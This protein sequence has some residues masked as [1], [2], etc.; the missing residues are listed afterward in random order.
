MDIYGPYNGF[1]SSQPGKNFE[2]GPANLFPEVTR[3]RV[4]LHKNSNAYSPYDDF[5]SAGNGS[6]SA[7]AVAKILDPLNGNAVIAQATISIAANRV[8]QGHGPG[9]YAIIVTSWSIATDVGG[10]MT[11]ASGTTGAFLLGAEVWSDAMVFAVSEA[12]GIGP[13]HLFGEFN[14]GAQN[15]PSYVLELSGTASQDWALSVGPVGL[16]SPRAILGAQAT[17]VDSVL[18][19][20]SPSNYQVRTGYSSV[21]STSP[22]VD[23]RWRFEKG[24][25]ISLPG[26]TLPAPKKRWLFPG[27]S[28]RNGLSFYDDQ[29]YKGQLV[30][31]AADGS[32]DR[33]PLSA[34]IH[35]VAVDLL[36][37]ETGKNWGAR[38]GYADPGNGSYPTSYPP[39][40][41]AATIGKSY[42][43]ASLTLVDDREPC[44]AKRGAYIFLMSQNARDGEWRLRRSDD[45]LKTFSDPV[46]IWPNTYKGARF[47][48]TIGGGMATIAVVNDTFPQQLQFKWS[49]D[50]LDWS[51]GN[52][53]GPV[54]IATPAGLD[55]SFTI[56]QFQ[57]SG[58]PVLLVS[59]ASNLAWKSDDMGRTWTAI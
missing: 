47:C 36:P 44:L 3:W 14:N 34:R 51:G 19:D 49:P 27:L 21:H 30:V 43:S 38:S 22:I 1:S 48:L 42:S 56:T 53:I 45:F 8:Y 55:Y 11:R 12:P 7:T 9:D 52:V 10:P 17:K 58:S 4:N 28:R 37:L 59:N 20:G 57:V 16:G 13:T 41:L 18:F 29:P 24:I 54:T 2:T 23:Y 25:P 32:W 50:P 26:E 6:G 31:V 35:R 40:T 33:A 46:N 39:L 15:R 5:G